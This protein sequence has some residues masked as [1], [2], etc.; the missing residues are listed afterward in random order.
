MKMNVIWMQFR[1]NPSGYCGVIYLHAILQFSND[2]ALG[3]KC[4][5]AAAPGEWQR[6]D[7][8]EEDEHLRHQEGEDLETHQ[9]QH[10]GHIVDCFADSARHASSK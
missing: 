4:E 8:G 5:E 1:W 2:G 9:C 3:D 10:D 6:N 7:Q